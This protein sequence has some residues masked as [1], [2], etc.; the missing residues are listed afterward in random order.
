M[1][2]ASSITILMNQLAPDLLGIWKNTVNTLVLF[3]NMTVIIVISMEFFLTDTKDVA[4][5]KKQLMAIA[6]AQAE[7]IDVTEATGT[8]VTNSKAANST[9]TL[10]TDD[11]EGP[12]MAHEHIYDQ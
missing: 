2:L 3:F 5:F 10:V 9:E 1:H 12:A 6:E 8:G 4:T 11:I 7:G